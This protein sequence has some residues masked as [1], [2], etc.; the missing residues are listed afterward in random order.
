[1]TKIYLAWTL[2]YPAMQNL[3]T[4]AGF[5]QPKNHDV[6]FATI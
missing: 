1:M 5:L 6:F 4:Y 2:L 3:H